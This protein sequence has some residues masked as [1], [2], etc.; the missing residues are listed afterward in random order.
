M[1]LFVLLLCRILQFCIGVFVEPEWL[2]RFSA[3]VIKRHL[4]NVLETGKKY[5]KGLGHTLQKWRFIFLLI[6]V[7]KKQ[8]NILQELIS[9]KHFF[10][11]LRYFGFSRILQTENLKPPWFQNQ[12]QSNPGSSQSHFQKNYD[13]ETVDACKNYC[14]E[15]KEK[16]KNIK[17]THFLFK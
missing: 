10:K 2:L 9:L 8:V 15:Q 5:I 6:I 3:C 1:S 13:S 16:R 14:F 7:W 17:T 12:C 4:R 11:K